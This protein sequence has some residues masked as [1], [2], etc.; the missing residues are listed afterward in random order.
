M[1]KQCPACHGDINWNMSEIHLIPNTIPFEAGY[2]GICEKCYSHIYLKFKAYE[3]EVIE[4]DE[5]MEERK[6]R[7][8]KIKKKE[9]EFL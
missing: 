5:Y 9:E 8:F 4:F 7:V 1:L 3:V 6:V 2:E